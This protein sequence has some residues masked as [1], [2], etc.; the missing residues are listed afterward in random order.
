MYYLPAYF[1]LRAT[2]LYSFLVILCATISIGY[3][4]PVLWIFFGL[5]QVITF[6]HFSTV[7]TEKW[8]RL[9]AN[10]YLKK[11]FRTSLWIR[12]IYVVI[13]YFFYTYMTGEPFEF[14]AADSKGYHYEAVWL[15]DLLQL[16]QFN[17][18]LEYI[19]GG[20][21]DMGYPFYLGMVY[22][23]FGKSIMVARLLKAIL[24]SYTCVL[25][26]KLASRNFGETAG[27]VAGIL[28]MLLPNLIYYCGLHL[29]E[30]EMIF[31]VVVFLER[32][33]FTLRNSKIDLKNL[34]VLIFTGLSLFFFRTVLGLSAFF[35]LCMTLVFSSSHLVM[36]SKRHIAIFVIVIGVYLLVGS[37]IE[38]ETSKH[39]EQRAT[40]QAASMAH[41]AN[42]ASGNQLAK[43]GSTVLFMPVVLTAPF[44]TLVNIDTQQNQMM[45]SGG[46][47]IKNIYAFFV[48]L[49]LFTIIKMKRYPFHILIISFLMA[50]L[51]VIASSKF[52]ISERFHLP[53]VP[54]LLV[55]ASYGITQLKNERYYV[56]YLILIAI[57]ILGWNWFKLAGRGLV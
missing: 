17:T 4:L 29:K 3:S 31:L 48:M 9:S 38:A 13:S 26:Y 15:V 23:L 50:Y 43:Y 28:A 16:N 47:Y 19:N 18:Y 35:A 54:V 57:F 53:A 33:D 11:L 6:F 10:G 21:S 55:F 37:G 7:L 22:S 12:I 41:R 46:Y 25:I 39:W 44:P 36:R 56:P 14:A 2:W 20:Y 27:R 52:A 24:S 34:C 8:S 45:L 30:T 51:G 32:A 40:N 49:A 5:V 1:T 42:I